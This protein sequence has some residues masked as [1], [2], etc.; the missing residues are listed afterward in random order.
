M[1]VGL[2][3]YFLITIGYDVFLLSLDC[4]L[5]LKVCG[6]NLT[7]EIYSTHKLKNI[8]QKFG[9]MKNN[10]IYVEMIKVLQYIFNLMIPSGKRF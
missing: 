1:N 6:S 2:V 4:L 9:K 10:L 3:F 7:V 5:S 8:S